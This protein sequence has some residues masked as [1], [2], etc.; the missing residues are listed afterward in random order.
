MLEVEHDDVDL[1]TKGGLDVTVPVEPLLAR[2]LLGGV[3]RLLLVRELG[4]EVVDRLPLRGARIGVD[5][6]EDRGGCGNEVCCSRARVRCPAAAREG[7]R[8]GRQ[9][10][11]T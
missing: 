5:R 6:D 8:D 4:G 3:D 10:E 9:A 7:E 11:K 2:A 1:W